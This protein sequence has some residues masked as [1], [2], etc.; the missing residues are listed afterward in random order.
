MAS[1]AMEQPGCGD[2]TIAWVTGRIARHVAAIR[3]EQLP[4]DIAEIARQTLLDWLA[5]TLAG[6]REELAAILRDEAAE[7]GGKPVATI[8]G[9]TMKTG[10][11]QAALV[12]GATSHAL[13]Y[14][15][16]NFVASAHCAVTIVPGMLALAEARDASGREFVA[17]LVAGFEAS[18]GA[19]AFVGQA[20]YQRGFHSTGTIGSFGSVG[21]CANL[22][23]LGPDAT[24]MAF[25]IAACQ[26][27]GI[28]AM[29]GTMCKPLH[30]GKAAQNGLIAA[31]LAARGY[32]SN[33]R[34]LECD[35]GFAATHSP[36]YNPAKTSVAPPPGGWYLFHNLFKYHAACYITHA[37][38]ECALKLHRDHDVGPREIETVRLRVQSSANDIC[39]IVE[40][41]SGLEAKFSL[42]QV[43]ASA[44]ADVDTAALETFSDDR[45][46]DPVLVALRKRVEIEFVPDMQRAYAEMDVLTKDGR[47]Y[48]S[49]HDAD[50]PMANLAEQGKRLR[51]KFQ[52]LAEPVLGRARTAELADVAMNVQA[53]GSMRDLTRLCLPE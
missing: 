19:G 40:P 17:A 7:Q 49:S 23:R 8:I 41:R 3:Y 35:Q 38:I 11:Q 4:P 29:F 37:P 36:D 10:T 15:D 50:K 12:N 43:I 33:P 18:G 47:R 46:V 5:V 6:S 13:D 30:A 20:H 45:V 21:A 39:N 24:A 53:L 2:A 51:N 1:T 28:R 48:S 16:T 32:T 31:T 52:R 22:M 44:F 42:R 26:T 34:A 27:A 14:D 25:G 9:H